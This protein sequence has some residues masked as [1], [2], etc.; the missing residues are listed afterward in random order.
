MPDDALFELAA[1]GKLHEPAVLEGQIKR[2][3][4]DAKS[5]AFVAN[6]E[7]QWLELRLLDDYEADRG[8]FPAWNRDLRNDMKQEAELFFRQVVK[9][10][11]S[12][13]D[14][15]SANYTF[16]NE[17]LAKFYGI[18]NVTG[19]NFRKVTLPGDAHRGGVLTMA[20]VLTV[21]A[22]PSRTSPVKRGKYVLEQIL[23]T[24]PPPPPPDVPALS[25]KKGAEP[26]SLRQ[27]LEQHRA[28]P[29]CASCHKRMDPIGFALENYDAIGHW[30][31]KEGTFTI[32]ASGVL[33]GNKKINGAD[34][35]KKVILERKDDFARCLV[36]KMLTYAIGRGI[37]P[38]DRATV[39]DICE[40]MRKDNY[41]FS[42]V[43]AGIV[44]SDAFLKQRVN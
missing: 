6:F 15:I 36:E 12:V 35:L 25:T 44:E 41:R 37:E 14:L 19:E 16:L 17:R 18:P 2:M 3:M 8:K 9:D 33:P 39:D 1:S 23:G 42:S 32:D 29:T 40:G 22:M 5:Q 4:G 28:D 30:R 24:P 43:L 11:A 21:T 13:L 27:R 38:Y 7:G 31:D 34:D 26:A 10:D 20:G